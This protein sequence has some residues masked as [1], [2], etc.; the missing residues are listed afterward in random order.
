M[1][2]TIF[3]ALAFVSSL[4]SFSA[5]ESITTNMVIDRN[6]Q[7][8][9]SYVTVGNGYVDENAKSGSL[10]NEGLIKAD[11]IYIQNGFLVNNGTIANH[12]PYEDILDGDLLVM[13]DEDGYLTNNGRIEG[14]VRAGA[15]TLNL[16]NGSYTQVVDVYAGTQLFVDGNITMEYLYLDDDC[17]V[18]F[19]LDSSIDLSGGVLEIYDARLVLLID[20]EIKNGDTETDFSY[21]NC[22]LFTNFSDNPYGGGIFSDKISVTIRDA[23]GNEATRSYSSLSVPE[24]AT[25]TLS[26]MALAAF[27]ARRRRK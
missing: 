7:K 24:P 13:W 14:Y 6:V 27:A 15:G 9:F 10:V 11:Q 21:L 25:A 22:N 12:E 17:E 2:K 4:A 20:E 26:L 3:L 18:T 19:T 8:D 1:K 23:N 16:T 5:A